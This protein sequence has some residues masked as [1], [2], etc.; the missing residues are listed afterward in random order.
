MKY[1]H[2][3]PKAHVTIV[4]GD[5]DAFAAYVGTHQGDGV[6][7]LCFQGEE[8]RIPGRSLTYGRQEDPA[9]QAQALFDALRMLDELGAQRVFARCPNREGVGL[10]VYNRLL[11]AAAFEEIAL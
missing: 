3:A 10:A 6:W 4:D 2:Y 8:G 5:L 1:K 7:A 9:S 11:R